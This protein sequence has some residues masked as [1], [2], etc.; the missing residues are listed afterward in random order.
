M[1]SF[2]LFMIAAIF[3][4]CAPNIARADIDHQCL[5]K[6]T[7][8]GENTSACMRKCSYATPNKPFD[9]SDQK[10]NLS[11]RNQFS[12][13]KSNSEEKENYY[14]LENEKTAINY[15]CLSDCLQEKSQY[16][17]CKRECSSKR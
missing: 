16:N 15:S 6:C 3:I 11:I 10:V 12:N 14:K 17:F 5:N 1:K 4:V 13:E 8:N 2:Y 7:N 9:K